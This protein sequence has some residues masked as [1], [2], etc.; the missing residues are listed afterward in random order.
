MSCRRIYYYRARHP[1][2]PLPDAHHPIP[3]V[4]LSTAAGETSPLLSP[5]LPDPVDLA[6][7]DKDDTPPVRRAVLYAL[8]VSFVAGVGIAAFYLAPHDNSDDDSKGNGD[9][10]VIELRS[11]L[12][13]WLSAALYRPFHPSLP[14]PSYN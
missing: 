8:A 1:V 4:F 2:H 9:E 6:K 3:G 12:L 10:V 7:S 14:L 11:Q 13:G 5:P